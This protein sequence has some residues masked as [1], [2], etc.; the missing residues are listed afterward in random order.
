M[1]G[2]KAKYGGGRSSGFATIYDDLDARKLYDT[3]PNLERDNIVERVK[4]QS[5]KLRKE[6]KGKRKRVKGTAKSKVQAGKKKK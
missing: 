6:L 5:R 2:L 4:N 1:F 3:K